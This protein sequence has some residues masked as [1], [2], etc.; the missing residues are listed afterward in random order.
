MGLYRGKRIDNGE[1]V[2]GFL[3][4]YPEGSE[5]NELHTHFIINE[6]RNAYS[7]LVECENTFCVNP[8][9]IGQY[10]GM[11]DKNGFKIFEGDVL[12][13]KT[14][15]LSNL[16]GSRKTVLKDDMVTLYE[17]VFYVDG[18]ARRYLSDTRWN[19]RWDNK[20]VISR[21]MNCPDRFYE[22]VGNIHDNPELLGGK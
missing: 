16:D 22:V 12:E 20:G 5:S 17:V 15:T 2:Y 7:E 18:W 19:E 13:Y 10:T 11:N 21:G 6:K 9:T 14:N 8:T 4:V 3:V 1:W